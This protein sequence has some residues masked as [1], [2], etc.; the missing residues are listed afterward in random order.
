MKVTHLDLINLCKIIKLDLWDNF[1][2]SY[3]YLKDLLDDL[4][5]ETVPNYN[6]VKSYNADRFFKEMF[7]V[8]C[9]DKCGVLCNIYETT[10]RENLVI[11][12]R[13]T[14]PDD[15]K[16]VLADLNIGLFKRF[17][18]QLL[19]AG[20]IGYKFDMSEYKH[21]FFTGH[22]LG[23]ALAQFSYF[24]INPAID[25]VNCIT[26]NNLG[27]TEDDIAKMYD[28]MINNIEMNIP[29]KNMLTIYQTDSY[30]T[31]YNKLYKHV[32]NHINNKSSYTVFEKSINLF[33]GLKF[34]LGFGGGYNRN[35]YVNDYDQEQYAR[36]DNDALKYEAAKIHIGNVLYVPFRNRTH[37][38]DSSN[39][40]FMLEAYSYDFTKDWTPNI[41]NQ[42]GNKVNMDTGDIT[43]TRF[44]ILIPTIKNFG[45]K[46]H[47]LDMFLP[48]L[49]SNNMLVPG[50]IQ[51]NFA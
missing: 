42:L 11:C 15:Y 3:V 17:D 6:L 33:G 12:F 47:S 23:G 43:F 45:F 31:I 34:S 44:K 37:F 49:D 19:I 25:S 36:I 39:S 1:T 5:P 26:F 2:D 4:Y 51:H 8:E 50:K 22:S 20:Y 41:N 35:E 30:D 16:D 21:I 18:L 27:I 9:T 48:Y 7:N 29:N 13:S 32:C 10:D 46:Y 40:N 14:D 28:G 38:Q 24:C